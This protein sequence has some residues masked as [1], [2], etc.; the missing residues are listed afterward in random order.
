MPYQDAPEF[1]KRVAAADGDDMRV[2][3]LAILV[4]LR[5][6]ETTFAVWSEVDLKNRLWM[7][8]WSR[9]KSTKAEAKKRGNR[10][11]GIV[12]T[13]RMVAIFRAMEAR[14][15]A[16]N[17]YVFPAQ[18]QPEKGKPINRAAIDVAMRKL[19]VDRNTAS[20]HGWRA[21]SWSSPSRTFTMAKHSR[22]GARAMRRRT[23]K[24]GE[25]TP[26]AAGRLVRRAMGRLE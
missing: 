8:P 14:R 21:T 25:L 2:L 7:I 17:L 11:H 5:S 6:T 19:G 9:M 13:D 23:A 24:S 18:R 26:G 20:P 22:T 10:P 1:L 16:G 12:L 3:E 4:G 15:V